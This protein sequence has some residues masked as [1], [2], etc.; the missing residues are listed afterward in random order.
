[1]E[2]NDD[3]QFVRDE[4]DDIDVQI[5]ELLIQR[6]Q[7]AVTAAIAKGN[8]HQDK[9]R[10]LDIIERTSDLAAEFFVDPKIVA[11]IFEKILELA[12]KQQS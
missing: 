5:V 4:I 3:L 7:L 9:Y 1:M 6:C 12:R 11:E 8:N 2:N 10:E